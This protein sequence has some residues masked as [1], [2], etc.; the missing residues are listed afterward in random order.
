M[1][2]PSVVS[3]FQAGL[4]SN[5]QVEPGMLV[6]LAGCDYEVGEGAAK[7]GIP[8]KAL[9]RNFAQTEV[10]KAMVRASLQ[11]LAAQGNRWSV[12]VGVAL[13]HY[14]DPTVRESVRQLWEGDDG[15][16]RLAGGQV[17]RIQNVRV[18]PETFGAVTELMADARRAEV[19]SQS[20]VV[21][22]DFGR[23][24]TGW[25]PFANGQPGNQTDSIDVGV[26]LLIERLTDKLRAATGV[27]SL[28]E[29]EAELAM[30]GKKTLFGPAVGGIRSP[31]DITPYLRGAT[32]LVWPQ[33]EAQ[34][35]SKLGD[36]RGLDVVAVGGGAK[37]FAENLKG[38]FGETNLLIPENAQDINALG[39]HRMAKA[40]E[41]T[42]L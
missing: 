12:V 39:M 20:K 27:P 26:S 4:Q 7:F 32:D 22:L 6:N 34:L 31:I 1:L 18:I 23:F 36:L 9:H 21:V 28:T 5:R 17:I 42:A 30:V 2:W 14:R 25:V 40:Q 37:A 24:T 15:I 8:L 11:R 35:R 29:A 38:S 3:E 41:H 19:W 33:I 10:Y 16:H 13:N